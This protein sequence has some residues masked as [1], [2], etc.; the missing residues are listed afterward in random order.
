MML[1]RCLGQNRDG[2]PCSAQARADGYCL[3]HSPDLAGERAAWRKRGG[4]RRSN[5]ARARAALPQDLRDVQDALYRALAAVEGGELEPPRANA[6]SA[7]AR[8]I[9]AVQ[10]VGDIEQRI[11]ALEAAIAAD[12]G[13]TA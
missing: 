2:A 4:E 1:E 13:K 5:R 8:A 12:A 7:L 9:V 11:A 3:W 6:M 10:Q